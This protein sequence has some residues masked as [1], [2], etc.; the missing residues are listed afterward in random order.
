M[1][2]TRSSEAHTYPM[3]HSC[4]SQREGG[5]YRGCLLQC[6][7]YLSLVRTGKYFGHL[8]VRTFPLTLSL[9]CYFTIKTVSRWHSLSAYIVHS[10]RFNSGPGVALCLPSWRHA[11]SAWVPLITRM[12]RYANS[13]GL[14]VR[15]ISPESTY[16]EREFTTLDM[17][18][19]VAGF[20]S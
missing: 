13:R 4:W 2:L 10:L 3:V 7:N 8:S 14:E 12:L 17:G 20:I 15:A 19:S 9:S 6:S 1:G 16:S 5:R 18:K 11:P